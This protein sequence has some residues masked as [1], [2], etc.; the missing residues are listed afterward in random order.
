MGKYTF[1]IRKQVLSGSFWSILSKIV[2][3]GT[4]FVSVPLTL[5]YLGSERM[6]L[7]RLTISMLTI[8]S[9]INAGLIPH[10][11]T[12]M[13]EAFAEKDDH[14]F[15]EYSSTGILIG[16]IVMLLGPLA[17]LFANAIDWVGLMK[18]SDPIAQKETL[19]L[20]IIIVVCTFAQVGSSFISAVFDAR[21]L[22][23]KPRINDLIGGVAGFLLLLVGIH[24]KVS[25][26][27]LAAFIVV[28]GILL[29]LSLLLVLYRTQ[30]GMIWPNLKTTKRVCRE[31][32]RPGI[33]A[34]GIQCGTI[35][36]S[37]SPNFI[38][39]RTLSLS[40]VT[41]FSIC[42]QLAT[43]PL[44]AIA[45]VVP[46]F[47]P[48]F[49]MLWRSGGQYKV[50]RWLFLICCMTVGLCTVFTIGLGIAGPWIIRLWTHGAVDPDRAFLILLGVFV[51]AQGVLHWLSTFMWSMNELR[52]QLVTQVASAVIL[53]VMG[54]LFSHLFGLHGI[55]MAM[56]TA[57]CV[58]ALGPMCW[59]TWTIVAG[60]SKS[61]LK[62]CQN[63]ENKCIA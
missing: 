12:R 47:W 2:Q 7:W 60:K 21:M 45:V 24:F 30:R 37:A 63:D 27:I 28:P 43:L 61:A 58:G 14:R 39:V 48:A 36:L 20:V 57:I 22:M 51:I 52:I 44:A 35:A 15:I 19:P 8:I 62:T 54:Y 25:L 6:G 32:A 23:S 4:A 31:L 50:G 13:A 34:V 9:F 56:S 3:V 40:D 41:H 5:Q 17:A 26:P 29:R 1:S 46:V 18:V 55:A 59:R 11:K 33:M 42:Y 49:I 10:I 53:V 38:V 16:F